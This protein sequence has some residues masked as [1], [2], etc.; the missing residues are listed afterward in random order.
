MLKKILLSITLIIFTVALRAQVT[1]SSITGKVTDHAGAPLQGATVVAT[2]TPTGTVYKGVTNDNGNINLGNVRV[3]GPYKIEISYVGLAPDVQEDVYLELGQPY[4]LQVKLQQAGQTMEE[5]L[6]VG[7]ANALMKRNR[8]GTSTTVT[9]TQIENLPS[10]SRSV[11]DLT[12]L[13]PQANGTAIGGGNYRSNNFT[14]DGA[15]FNNQFGI[16]Q[17]VPAG[18]SPIS[19]DAIEQ[20]TVNVTPYDVRQTGFTGAAINAVTR[21]GRNEFFGTAFYTGRSDKQQG[22][23]VEDFNITNIAPLKIQQYGASLG[24][25]II[26]NKLFFFLNFEQMKQTE[27]GPTK[28]AQTP[29]N[30]WSP[31]NTNVARPRASF[32]DSVRNYLIS[33]YG[34]DPG[35]YQ[36]YSYKSDNT[37]MFGRIDWNIATGHKINFRYSQVESKTP[38][39]I[40][41][42]TTNQGISYA[43]SRTANTAMHFAN[44]NYFQEDNLYTGTLEYNGKI[45]NLNHSFRASYVHQNAPRSSPGGLF[46]LVDILSNE[47]GLSGNN[48]LTTFGYEPFTFGNLRDVK[49]LTLNYD[50][51]Y[52]LGDHTLTG[53]IQYET[54]RTK[55]GFQRFGTGAYT[56][57]SWEDFVN[58]AKP[59]N[60]ALTFPLTEDG[61]QA[62]PSFKF[63]QWS[64]YLQDE[65]NITPNFKLMAGL[66]VELP[67]YPNVAEIK[68]HPL[69]AEATFANGMKINTGSLPKTT[70][71]LSPRL[72]FNYDILGDRSLVLRGGS[73]IFTGR[74]PYVWI[75]AQSG[76]AGMLQFLQSYQAGDPN[77]PNFS[78][79]IKANYPST[80]PQAGTSIPSSVSAMASN[81]KFPSTWKSSLALDVKLPWN[82]IG[83][84]EGIYNKDINGVVAMNA[85]LVDPT[86]MNIA[87]YP[88]NRY[89]FPSGANRYINKL[90]TDVNG[91]RVIDPSGTS[92]FDAIVMKNAKGGH[93]W[94]TTV[95]L[96]KLFER[97]FSATIAY[98]RSGAKN[99]GDGSGDQIANLWS[100]PFQNTGNPNEPSLS[101]TSNVLPSR[102]V[103]SVTYSNNWIGNLKTSVT[104]FYTGGHQG[105]YSY[106]YSSDFNNDGQVNDLIYV[107]KDPSEIV[108]VTASGSA[109]GGKTYTPEEQ[110]EIF[111]N[112]IEKDKYLRKRKGMYAERNGAVLPWRNQFDLR[113]AQQI[114]NGLGGAKHSLE[115][116]W[117]V[118]NV[119]NLFNPHWGVYKIANSNILVPA[120]TAPDG[121]PQFRINS[122]NGDIIRDPYRTN[123][124]I[125]S[126][127]YMQFG[128]RYTFN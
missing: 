5:V 51:S 12:R 58:G 31:S 121:R 104:L 35:P 88:D 46:P 34:Y 123:Q 14:V 92:G 47:G 119:G 7:R 17:N 9:R 24:G 126:T 29:S 111:M 16:G 83:T 36:G 54:S 67:S 114:F 4:V 28:I 70:A 53:G 93:Y 33:N 80:L 48:V 103:G 115:V 68:T 60:Y 3:G 102:L 8:I 49:T 39:L 78:P 19:L 56:F 6:V 113:F 63:A 25:P 98:T 81:L 37:K 90:I 73:G 100:L 74:I 89:I 79:D 76:D 1:T 105:R 22:Y 94:A 72:G 108:F 99:F 26:K 112:F 59:I 23:R 38:S 75:V 116:F 82:I 43:G 61:S 42:S 118:F 107:P 85:N 97:G 2:H 44:S 10:I 106:S 40:S 13:A 66:R 20:I 52:T 27:P 84:I 32:L 96:T 110:M 45:G 128:I 86:R 117:D 55:N 125:T 65:F 69:V 71:M 64:L 101:Y 124:T 57:A 11:N 41:A 62:F 87:G 15:N 91:N 122:A 21:S 77:M 95:S 18:G 30:P 109:Y 50:A 120:G 127:Y